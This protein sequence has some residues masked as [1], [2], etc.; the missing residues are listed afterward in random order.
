MQAEF[1]LATLRAINKRGI[2]TALETCGYFNEKL[3]DDL[4]ESVDLFLFDIKHL[5]PDI[6]RRFT[7]VSNEKILSNFSQIL[8]RVGSDRILPR[9]PV[10]PGYNDDTG[11]IEK[12]ISYLRGTGYSGHV[13]LMPY[14]RMAKTK[15]EKIGKGSSYK[16]MG[17]QTDDDL[18][19][20][21]SKFKHAS[22]ETVCNR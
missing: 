8:L 16:D 1:L 18:D 9:I 13:H 4:I 5:D 10:I 11:S 15:W 20:I 21:I 17:L 12:I 14:N 7:G 3:Q 22:L 19:R 6:H 2:H